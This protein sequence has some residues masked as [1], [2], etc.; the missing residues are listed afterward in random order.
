[1]NGTQTAHDV[2]TSPTADTLPTE[3]ATSINAADAMDL[4]LMCGECCDEPEVAAAT[5]AVDTADNCFCLDCNTA[6]AVLLED[7]SRWISLTYG[8]ML[9]PSCAREHGMLSE[10]SSVHRLS[11]LHETVVR[12]ALARGGSG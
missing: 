6:L 4:M 1:M 8:T 11:D 10:H 3:P 7:S 9:C 2:D 12:E 5:S